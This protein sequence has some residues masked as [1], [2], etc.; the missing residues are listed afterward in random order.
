MVAAWF[1]SLLLLLRGEVELNPGPKRNSTNTFSICHWN[2][3]IISAHCY[4]L[5]LRLTLQF[6]SLIFFCILEKDL[7]CSTPPDDSNLEISGHTLV[8]SDHSSNNK[9][10]AEAVAR[11][12]SVKKVFLKISQNSQENTFAKVS[13]SVKLQPKACNFINKEALAQ[14]F[15]CAFCEI[16]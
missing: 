3:D 5:S 12:C 13:F 15:F 9:R 4:A 10:R 6:V 7:D 8:R 11:M 16:F 2:L 1:Y 14:V